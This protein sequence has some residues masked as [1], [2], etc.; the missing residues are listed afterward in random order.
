M[1]VLPGELLHDPAVRAALAQA[2]QESNPGVSGGHEEGGFI[3]R[4]IEGGLNVVRWP[5]G[6]QYTILVSPHD[7]CRI[8]GA[9]IV[10]T[11][12]SHPNTGSN[13]MQEPGVTDRRAVRDDPNLKGPEYIGEYVLAD[14]TI[15]FIAPNGEVHAIGSRIELLSQ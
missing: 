6:A 15:Y 3:V 4:N 8:D 11:F 1:S 13:A 12:H 10:A 9:D 5:R 14:E 7:R 2:W